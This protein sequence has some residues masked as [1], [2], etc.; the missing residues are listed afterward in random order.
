[1]LYTKKDTYQKELTHYLPQ[2]LQNLI[3][4]L[5]VLKET[6]MLQRKIQNTS[7]LMFVEAIILLTKQLL[8]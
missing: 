3:L 2:Q 1:M 4:I 8:M 6:L 5:A 7:M